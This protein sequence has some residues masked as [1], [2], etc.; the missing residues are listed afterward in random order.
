MTSAVNRIPWWQCIQTA[1]TSKTWLLDPGLPW[2]T[3]QAYQ[4]RCLESSKPLPATP[5]PS[6]CS[7]SL[8]PDILSWGFCTPACSRCVC[9][10][11]PCTPTILP[12]ISSKPHNYLWSQANWC[13][14]SDDGLHLAPGA[15]QWSPL[16]WPMGKRSLLDRF[17]PASCP[18]PAKSPG[19]S[20]SMHPGCS[21]PVCYQ[22]E[23]EC[24]TAAPPPR[25]LGN[26]SNG[27]SIFHIS[28]GEG[29]MSSVPAMS[30]CFPLFPVRTHQ[31]GI[32]LLSVPL[33]FLPGSPPR[34][35]PLSLALLDPVPLTS[36]TSF[37]NLSLLFLNDLKWTFML[38]HPATW[39]RVLLK[40]FRLQRNS[41]LTSLTADT[42]PL[43]T[44][45]LPSVL[46]PLLP[47]TKGAGAWASQLPAGCLWPVLIIPPLKSS[48]SLL[49]K[50]SWVL[51]PSSQAQ[52][53]CLLPLTPTWL[54]LPTSHLYL[55]P[56]TWEKSCT[57]DVLLS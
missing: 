47:G 53:H 17:L 40:L 50:A 18:G 48:T 21:L 22:P 38:H 51:S 28:P 24:L 10:M 16:L 36:W 46:L 45:L 3:S 14:V 42:E 57:Y 20:P 2:Y 44:V 15:F 54:S 9:S 1:C 35:L 23:K 33:P 19:P 56:I 41:P 29:S 32:W 37:N 8:A 11:S 27:A 31:A 39:A 25:P 4:S 30:L 7:W 26:G 5:Y 52:G 34:S 6:P 43:A 49:S 55:P 12:G 13:H